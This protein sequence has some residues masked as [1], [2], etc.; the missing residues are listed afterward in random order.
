MPGYS[1]PA[2]VSLADHR[3]LRA[4]LDSDRLL[5]W[6]TF[7]RANG[8]VGDADSGQT[9][10]ILSGT[11]SISGGRAISS[12]GRIALDAGAADLDVEATV[13][14]A[15]FVALLFRVTDN[16]NHIEL[17]LTDASVAL[18]KWVAGSPSTLAANVASPHIA[19]REY[20]LRVVVRGAR[21]QAFRDGVRV[22]DV[23][24]SGGDETTFGTQTS[25]GV[26]ASTG[27]ALLSLAVRR[28]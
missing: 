2:R 4:A 15:P 21:I 26:R 8:P 16:D 9:Y 23:T 1:G 7:D 22:H 10:S 11:W 18:R 12:S 20:R 14:Y 17:Q 25:V 3:K 6:D 19:G 13:H 27:A 5:A 24:M 28:A